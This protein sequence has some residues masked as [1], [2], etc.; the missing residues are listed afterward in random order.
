MDIAFPLKSQLFLPGL[1]FCLET[2]A[3][4]CP[5]GSSCSIGNQ[6][7]S[8]WRPGPCCPSACWSSLSLSAACS[9][10]GGVALC[11]SLLSGSITFTPSLALRGLLLG[12]GPVLGLWL[13]PNF[14]L[15]VCIFW[16]LVHLCL[17]VFLSPASSAAVGSGPPPEAEQAW[18]QSSGEEEL[19]LQLALAMSKEEADQVWGTAAGEGMTSVL[20][21]C[22]H[23]SPSQLSTCTSSPLPCSASVLVLPGPVSSSFL[24]GS[25]P[26]LWQ[27][28]AQLL[29]F[30][31]HLH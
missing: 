15:W 19:Q 22:P 25:C 10:E 2:E 5:L 7:R 20:P 30:S 8:L 9:S 31:V 23:A 4:F 14:L 27:S 16:S 29:S 11:P 3:I 1:Q 12:R 21:S 13:Q 6:G 26:E 28:G 18:P 17:N 24:L